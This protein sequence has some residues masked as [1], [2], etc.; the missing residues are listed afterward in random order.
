MILCVPPH[1]EEN[2]YLAYVWQIL[3]HDRMHFAYVWHVIRKSLG[4]GVGIPTFTPRLFRLR[5]HT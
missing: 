4:V 2:L 1:A 3:G 5:C